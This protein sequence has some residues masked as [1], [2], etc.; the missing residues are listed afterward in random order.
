MSILKTSIHGTPFCYGGIRGNWNLNEAYMDAFDSSGSFLRRWGGRD[1]HHSESNYQFCHSY[2][3]LQ[4][5]RL[6][7][8]A[9]GIGRERFTKYQVISP[10]VY[11][12]IRTW[13]IFLAIHFWIWSCHKLKQRISMNCS[14]H[15]GL[16]KITV[17]D[18]KL[19]YC[20]CNIK[21]K[22]YEYWRNLN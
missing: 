17:N 16:S 5:H 19:A 3:A 22:S 4:M 10:D 20:L 21:I 18:G 6:Q 1:S 2:N 14:F 12:W 8:H 15:W 7:H 9:H 11:H 13:V